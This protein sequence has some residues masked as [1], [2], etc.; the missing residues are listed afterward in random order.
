[1]AV[2]DKELGSLFSVITEGLTS[3]IRDGETLMDSEGNP[4]KKTASPAYFAAGIALLKNNNITA[5]ATGNAELVA[6]AE[7]LKARRNKKVHPLALEAAAQ[8]YADRHTLQ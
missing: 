4:V 5:D 6:L 8:E 2:T 3:V 7:Q 1:M